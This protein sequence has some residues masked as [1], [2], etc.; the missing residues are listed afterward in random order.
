MLEPQH[1]SGDL[2]DGSMVLFDDGAQV[3]VLAHLDVNAGVSLDTFHTGRV[4][5]ALVDGALLTHVVQVDGT[6]QKPTRY[7]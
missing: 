4:G 6:L 1:R 5:A 3:L 2:F 7:S